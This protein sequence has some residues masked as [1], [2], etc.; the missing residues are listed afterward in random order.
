MLAMAKFI[1]VLLIAL[2]LLVVSPAQAETCK[3]IGDKTVCIL[4]IK[5]SAKNYWQ[6]KAT[7]QIN[8]KKRPSQLYNC[9]SKNRII[10]KGIV[11]PFSQNGAGELICS[12]FRM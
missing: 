2:S 11:I 10:A 1:L 3:Q 6:Y 8:G 9:R 4:K 12:F 7:V 5:R